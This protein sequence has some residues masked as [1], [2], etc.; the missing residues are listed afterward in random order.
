[1]MLRISSLIALTG[2]A[3]VC[4]AHAELVPSS[5]DVNYVTYDE[6]VQIALHDNVDLLTLRSQEESLKYQSKQAIAPNEP[7]FSYARNDVPSFSLSQLP[8]QTVYQINW[9]LGFPGKAL[10][11][12]AAISHQAEATAQQALTQE[13][14]IM[15]SLSNSYVAF[16]TNAAFYKFLLDEQK[17]DKELKK[18]IE[19]KFAASQASKV[20]LLNAE[21]ATQQI[22]QSILENRNDYDVQLTLFRQIIRRPSDTTLMPK[23]PEKIVIPPVK[24]SFVELVPV[25]LKNNHAVTA[26]ARVMDSQSALLTNSMLQALPDLQLFANLNEWIP[27]GAP[28]GPNVLRD[29]SMGVGVVIPIFFP[30]NELQ[31]IHAAREN[32]GAAENQFTSQQL[33]AI[34]ALQTAYTSL[35]ATL[36]DLDTSERL[37][38]PAA[39]S[40][41][42][43]TLVTYGLGKADY[44]IVNQSRQAWHEASRDMLT[45]RQTAAQ[46]YNQLITQMGCDI[47]KTEGPNACK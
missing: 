28:N 42:D 9:T 34:A 25:M 37:V 13:I 16:A 21:V 8:A 17:S 45:K 43:L 44:L 33:Q 30:F 36:K 14:N 38:V 2:L 19:K 29:Y 35:N 10:A 31:G 40:S 3:T 7:V 5:P 4:A 15:T 27:A 41:F 18:L 47:A 46:L 24:Q 1:M 26:A 39:K 32:L 12:S 20:E 6:A 11:N 22:A 23:I